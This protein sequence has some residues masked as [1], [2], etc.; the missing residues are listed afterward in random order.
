MRLKRERI[1]LAL[2]ALLSTLSFFAGYQIQGLSQFDQQ[3][4]LLSF[5][6][7]ETSC[8][9]DNLI[10]CIYLENLGE[11]QF[12][13]GHMEQDSWRVQLIGDSN[14][15]KEV[16]VLR[17]RTGGLKAREVGYLIA[18]VGTYTSELAEL[19][20]LEVTK[21]NLAFWSSNINLDKTVCKWIV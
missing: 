12:T 15:K 7:H 2:L 13:Q 10:I 6:G 11:A 9:D 3:S 4:Y 16:A 18:Y 21:T 5:I 1:F 8:L 20:M 17:T 19:N 14:Q